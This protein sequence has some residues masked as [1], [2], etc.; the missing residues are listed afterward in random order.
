[1]LSL[2]EVEIV[3]KIEEFKK[4][5]EEGEEMLFSLVEYKNCRG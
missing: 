5:I 2:E 3:V 1:M 4:V